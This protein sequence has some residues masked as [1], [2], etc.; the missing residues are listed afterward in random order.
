MEPCEEP[1]LHCP[2]VN[3]GLQHYA[4]RTELALTG[5]LLAGLLRVLS[6]LGDT[7]VA[8]VGLLLELEATDLDVLAAAVERSSGGSLQPGDL[9]TISRDAPHSLDHERTF[10]RCERH[11]ERLALGTITGDDGLLGTEHRDVPDSGVLI[12]A[13]AEARL[14]GS[15]TVV[16]PVLTTLRR[17]IAEADLLCG[18]TT[19]GELRAVG[20][21]VGNLEA[22]RAGFPDTADRQTAGLQLEGLTALVLARAGNRQQVVTDRDDA[23]VTATHRSGTAEVGVPNPHADLELLVSG[24][25]LED[26]PNLVM[27][28]VTDPDPIDR[29]IQNRD[30][31]DDGQRLAVLVR[32]Q[33]AP[34]E[35]ESGRSHLEVS[36]VGGAHGLF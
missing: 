14:M 18:L 12:P 35:V 8:R 6:D 19:V 9:V 16:D 33:H 3:N 4:H 11:L 22:V 17:T 28:V 20:P 21:E 23:I 15:E 27:V 25:A 32:D 30:A 26:V 31:G 34:I 36:F 5:S 1:H 10:G 24:A 2:G 7:A 29:T 13:R